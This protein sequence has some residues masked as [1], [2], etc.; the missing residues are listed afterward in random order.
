MVVYVLNDSSEPHDSSQ[1]ARPRPTNA[2]PELTKPTSRSIKHTNVRVAQLELATSAPPLER[3]HR[4][5]HFYAGGLPARILAGEQRKK[6]EELRSISRACVAHQRETSLK[7]PRT[8]SEP[9]QVPSSDKTSEDQTQ[10]TQLEKIGL[11]AYE[12]L[13]PAV[14]TPCLVGIDNP[15]RDESCVDRDTPD[16]I[17]LLGHL[18]PPSMASFKGAK[19]TKKVQHFACAP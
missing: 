14:I 1:E 13:K 2:W 19:S 18:R 5:G 15:K 11:R 3:I 7:S 8:N 4:Q 10:S 9:E 16:M 12:D 17:G 6:F